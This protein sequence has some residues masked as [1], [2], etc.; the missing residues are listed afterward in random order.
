MLF[1]LTLFTC[2]LPP[3]RLPVRK[4][5][6]TVE[7]TNIREVSGRMYVGIF[8]PT[9]TFP[10]GPPMTKQSVAVDGHTIRVAFQLDQGEYAVALYQDVNSNGHIDKRMFGLPKEPYGFSNNVRPRLATPKFEECRVLLQD[11][12]KTLISL[13]N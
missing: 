7:V 13:I 4:V 10:Q 5:T 11:D 1:F 12:A 3:H 9:N 6:L 2:L 8:K